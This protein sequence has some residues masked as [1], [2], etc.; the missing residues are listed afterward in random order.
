MVEVTFKVKRDMD[1]CKD[2]KDNPKN[3]T[4]MQRIKKMFERFDYPTTCG[5]CT[6]EVIINR[7][8]KKK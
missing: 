1:K 3:M 5:L 4:I 8:K 7:I 6:A 2:C